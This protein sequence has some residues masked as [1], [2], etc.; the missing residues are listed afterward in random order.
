MTVTNGTYGGNSASTPGEDGIL[1]DANNTADQ[2]VS[3]SGAS[4]VNNKS[5]H[6]QFSTG[7]TGTP[8]Q[9]VSITGTQMST[10]TAGDPNVAGGGIT[11]SPAGGA[12]VDATISGNNIQNSKNRAIRVDTTGSSTGTDHLDATITGNTIGTA[13]SASGRSGAFSSDG[14]FL[15]ANGSAT[16]DVLM[17]G[18]FIREWSNTHGIFMNHSG[19][20]PTLNATITDND[21]TNPSGALGGAGGVMARAGVLGTDAGTMCLDLGDSDL[22]NPP[23]LRN[24]LGGAGTSDSP[25]SAFNDI[26]VEKGGTASMQ[27]PGLGSTALTTYLRDRNTGSPSVSTVGSGFQSTSNPCPQPD[28]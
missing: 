9:D 8:R 19:P 24:D 18:N 15:G 16:V 5:D 7:S 26:R 17:T 3:I 27:F 28:P 1:V 22:N 11:I 2:T 4:F 25:A 20:N 21:L 13:G 6:V 14:V 23:D 12:I 10:T